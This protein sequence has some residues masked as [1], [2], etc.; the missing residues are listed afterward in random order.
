MAVDW[1]PG[2]RH[3]TAFCLRDESKSREYL[4]KACFANQ[5]LDFPRCTHCCSSK[6]FAAIVCG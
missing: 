3:W 6:F 4:F 5:E 2:N 1:V